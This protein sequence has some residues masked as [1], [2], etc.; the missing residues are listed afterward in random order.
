MMTTPLVRLIDERCAALGLDEAEL[1]RRL[2]FKS[3]SKT[4]RRLSELRGGRIVLPHLVDALPG[5]LGVPEA[6]W[7]EVVRQSFDMLADEKA[8]QAEAAEQRRER[9]WREGFVPH[10]MWLVERAVPRPILQV[11]FSG[12]D[13]FLRHDWPAGLPPSQ[14]LEHALAAMPERAGPFGAVLGV[15]INDTP[16]SATLHARDGTLIEAMDRA[17]R[18][19]RASLRM[20][21]GMV[22]E[23]LSWLA[24]EPGMADIAERGERDQNRK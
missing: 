18:A 23:G 24:P 19:G 7:R 20:R 21:G 12:T 6:Q 10:A 15:A 1:A 11:A 2:P 22:P 13:V 14:R 4:R 3:W 5:V 8:R 16:D 9:E 17:V